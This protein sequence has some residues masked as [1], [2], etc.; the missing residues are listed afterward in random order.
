[1]LKLAGYPIVINY[2]FHTQRRYGSEEQRL[3]EA[4]QYEAERQLDIKI[5][6]TS[7][8]G[9]ENNLWKGE[10]EQYE[11]TVYK[12][13]QK[14][15]SNLVGKMVLGLINKQTTV[16]IIPTSDVHPRTAQT[17]PLRYDIPGDGSYAYGA[18]SGDT[19]ITFRPEQ[20]DITLFH[21]L[22]H[23]YRYSYDKF[24]PMF[25]YYSVPERPNERQTTEE[26]LA[27]QMENIYRSQGHRP[28]TMDY[29]YASVAD[30]KAIYDFLLENIEMVQTLKFFLRHEHLAML[31]AHSFAT[32]YNPFRD[33]AM[34]EASILKDYSLREL[35]EMGPKV[36]N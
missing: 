6:T 27:H 31:A 8:S 35:Y 23:A 7:D 21:E 20:G 22:V 11:A 36:K 28:L 12:C 9:I 34:L 2:N 13:L 24:H 25:L 1:M 5:N 26:F 32:D 33:Y 29:W 15:C 4:G 3:H 10:L 16:W 19:V 17:R 14:V 30:R 18:G